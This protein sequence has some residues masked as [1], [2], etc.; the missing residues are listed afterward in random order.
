MPW[1][2]WGDGQSRSLEPWLRRLAA[3]RPFTATLHR[4]RQMTL[5]GVGHPSCQLEPSH[6]ECRATGYMWERGW[7]R[8]LYFRGGVFTS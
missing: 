1:P 6:A 3:T 8:L 5:A 7:F 4:V 2:R